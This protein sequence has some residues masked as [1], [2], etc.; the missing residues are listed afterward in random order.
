[1]PE[2]PEVETIRKQIET[3]LVGLT[4]TSI[5]E[6]PHKMFRGNPTELVG[7]KIIAARRF[8][9]L[10]VI[11]FSDHV[12]LAIHLKMTGRLTL[13]E[14]DKPLPDHTHV[15]FHLLPLPSKEGAGVVGA[16]GEKEFVLIYSDYRR[17][18]FLQIV[19]TDKVEQLPF[20]KKLGNEPLKDFTLQYFQTLCAK[21]KRPI[22]TL[23]M[24][25]EKIAGIGNI[26]VS[27]ALW[28]AKINP[29]KKANEVT[30]QELHTLF[31]AIESSLKEGIRR[32]GAS[33]NSYRDLLGGKGTYQ[34]FFKVY[35]RAGEKCS[36]CET[37]IER[38]IQAG[39]ST[40]F[41][42]KCQG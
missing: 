41:C 20:I 26:Y 38:I 34:N 1:M 25:Q 35:N 8:G 11:D 27:E 10:L 21:A 18:G 5:E 23:L 30:T 24:D 42:P 3:Y 37:S 28:L 19:P 36:R 17:F 13:Q 14:K 16:K 22:K 4:I 33:D 7:K 9:K 15:I 32:R 31:N 2:L 40:F 39:R 12:S 6:R 29:T